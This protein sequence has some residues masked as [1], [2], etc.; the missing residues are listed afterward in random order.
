MISLK[1]NL[2]KRISA[3]AVA[4]ALLGT[5]LPEDLGSVGLFDGF[6]LTADA[7]QTVTYIEYSWNGSALKTTE[8]EATSYTVVTKDLVKNSSEGTGKGLQS[9]TYVVNANTT[10]EDYVYIRKNN[11]VN[12]IVRDGVTLT[13]KK[14]IGCGYDKNNEAARLNI[15]GGGTIVTTGE[16]D[17]AGIGGKDD[18]TNGWITI[19]GTTIKATGGDHAAGIGGGDG[20]KDPNET[21]PTITIYDGDI[22]A[23]GGIDGAGIGGG[24]E[25]PGARTYIYKGTITASSEKHGAGIG[26]GDEEGTYGVH[27]YGGKVTATGGEHGAGIGAGEGGGNLRKKADGGGVN[28]YGGTVTATGGKNAAGIGGGYNEDVSGEINISGESTKLT[29]TGVDGAA[30]IG[31]GRAERGVISTDKGDMGG[32]ITINCGKSSEL[33]IC[34]GDNHKNADSYNSRGGAGIGAGFGG[35]LYGKVY[36]K[37]GNIDITSGYNA[38][39]IGGGSEDGSA[40]GEGGDVYIG[41]GNITIHLQYDALDG[42]DS[43]A[44]GAGHA[45]SKSGSVYIHKNNNT[46]GKYMSVSYK[47]YGK[48]DEAFKT[49]S[50]S[51]R[52][53]KCHT[54]ST[55][56]IRECDEH[57]HEDLEGSSGLT[58][59]IDD[60][61]HI[62]KCR[63]CGYED[64]GPHESELYC[65]CGYKSGN[66]CDITIITQYGSPVQMDASHTVVAS[67]KKFLIPECD[68]KPTGM[69]FIGWAINGDDD[70]SNLKKPGETITI[71]S[72][73]TLNAQYAELYHIRKNTNVPNGWIDA[74]K[75]S[76]D[77]D[78]KITVRSEPDAGYKLK[79]VTVRENDAAGTEIFKKTIHDGNTSFEFDMP[80]CNIYIDAEFELIT[81]TVFISGTEHGTVTADKQIIGAGS[82]NVIVTL[83]VKSDT[84]YHLETITCS[85]YGGEET[86]EVKLTKVDDT[87]YTFEM[88]SCDVRVT[89]EFEINTYTVTW[90]NADGTVLEKDENVE[91]GTVPSYDGKTPTKAAD[92]QYTYKFSGWDKTPASVTAN[93]TYTAVFSKTT[94]E[95]SLTLPKNMS[96]VSGAADKYPYA[97]TVRFKVNSGYVVIGDVKNGST[98]IAESSGVYSVTIKADTTVTAITGTKVERVEPTCEKPG[99]LLYYKGSDGKLYGNTSG[100]IVIIDAVIPAKGHSYGTPSYTWSSD[101]KTCTAKAV[102]KNDSTHTVTETVTATYAVTKAPTTSSE[103]VGTYTAEF[104]NS[105]FGKQTATIILEKE[106]II[107]NAP[108]YSW[109]KTS[110]GYTCTATRTAANDPSQSPQTQ[111]VTAGYSVTKAAGCETSGIGTY[112]AAFTNTAFSTQ[113]RTV[114]IAAAGHKFGDWT[115]T[116]AATCIQA[117]TQTRKCSACAKTETKTIAKLGHSYKDTTVKATCEE[118]GYTQHTCTRCGDMY[119]DTYTDAT[120]HKFSSWTTTKAATCTQAGTQ[121]R[122]CS[123]CAKTE[124]K[125]I[126]ML[127]HSYTDTVVKA[128]CEEKGY[129]QHKCSRCGDVY[130]DTYTNAAGHKFGEWKQTKAASCTQ[131]GTLT[132]ECSVCKK[133]ETNITEALGHNMTK[134]AANEATCTAAGNRVYWS[135]ATCRKYFVDNEGK[136]E[137]PK[138]SWIIEAT[139]HSY[140]DKVVAATCTAKGYTE[141]KCSRCGDSYKD[142]YTNMIPHRWGEWKIT[143]PATQ[144]TK[145]TKQR[146]CSV[147]KQSETLEIPVTTH[148]HTYTGKIVAPTC[149]EKGYTLHTCE[150]GNYYADTYTDA[151][152]HNWSDWTVTKQATETATGVKERSCS[153]CKI[154]ETESIPTAVHKHDYSIKIVVAPT[155]TEKGYTLRVCKC[156]DEKRESYTAA[157]GHSFTDWTTT[158]AATCLSEGSRVREC[159]VCAKT[160]TET[161]AKL[162]HDYKT[163]VVDPTCTEKGYTLHRCSRCGDNYK[164]TQTAAAGHKWNDWTVVK[165]ATCTAT[166]TRTRQCK[167]CSNTETGTIAKFGHSYK[168]TVVDPTCTAKG[169]TLHEC[170]RCGVSSKDNYTNIA[171]H[172]WSDWT[173]TK[174]ATC[175]ATGTKTRKCKVCGMTETG[176]IAKLGHSYKTTVVKPTCTAKGYTLHEC[177][178][179]GASNKDNYTNTVAH[180]WGEWEQTVKPTLTKEGKNERKCTVCGKTETQTL[181]KA[182]LVVDRLAGTTRFT[183]AVEISKKSFEKADTV[184]L[185]YGL[186]YAD[187]LAGI[188]LAHK[189][190]AP[191]LL[192]ET[193]TLTAETLAEIKRLGAKKVI[194]LGGTGVISENVEK[195][196]RNNKIEPERIAGKT[197]FSTAAAIAEK[198]SAKPTDVFLIYGLDFPD[199]LS[200]STVAAIKGS[201]ILYLTKNGKLDSDTAAYLAKL[202]KAGSV[203]NVYVIGGTGVISDDMMK[204]AVKALGLSKATRIAGADRFMTCV[205]VNEYFKDAF[206]SDK[207]CVATG[208]DFP[209]AL[210]GGAYAAKNNAPLLLLNG[211]L[212]T[213]NLSDELKKFVKSK[214]P[215]NITV[216][217][218]TGAVAENHIK[219]LSRN[220][221]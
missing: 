29:A 116:K 180:K 9:G 26:G 119:K 120:G 80:D 104:K 19:H 1:R 213:P 219:D 151:L 89:A 215:L 50:A 108:T 90:K 77:V 184:I 200:A 128:T 171:A 14:G 42:K 73:T 43:E 192:T 214:Q 117:G 24:D 137:I 105:L 181:P 153:V 82:D 71:T 39:G 177:T 112:T 152:T 141:H 32:T 160:E 165:P 149:T 3:A 158:K 16:S 64:Q 122:K 148:V 173:T 87:H 33:K 101:K 5:S 103:G 161:I 2:F 196:L 93:V 186:N 167:F 78:D 107:W 100:S 198:L 221:I 208:M 155:C 127:G 201:P 13:C 111:T 11:T 25:Q 67:G 27:I 207:I 175:T 164:D 114:E 81:R 58:Y 123:A 54:R 55:L 195:T 79:S 65:Y 10:I 144:T 172:N 113:T 203:R 154:K 210:V 135:C 47:P 18:E 132:R 102:C 204:Q 190:N 52:S 140:T 74:S 12:L 63:F 49:V 62:G 20:G 163:T 70:P 8:R 126:A 34:G 124:T 96:V 68:K 162:G 133:T 15:Y 6:S 22:T 170:T 147:C 211:K 30:G 179:C 185:A 4:L 61:Q 44:I 194:I 48:D 86:S 159:K 75:D 56:L 94:R 168:T 136:I 51:D 35:N 66:A 143:V 106:K 23:T 189:L 17:A 217:G 109:T 131:T 95:Y 110:S 220:I 191:I 37:G 209:D 146:T 193:K 150:C 176:T 197:R 115:T 199:A 84:G 36:I 130:K 45:D 205:A 98:V 46:T 53:K 88:P 212:K 99:N 157:S 206:T 216:F 118:Q 182:E 83:T 85:T 28:I 72:D 178:R 91:H 166:G 40:G 41:G 92:A 21:S 156:G 138:D 60:K 218:G 97:A 129:T 187:A 134:T 57:F 7:A 183:T 145:G 38:A 76:A 69:R 188:P 202:K 121:T 174:A 31:A 139:G 125:T 142:S 169:Y 59:I